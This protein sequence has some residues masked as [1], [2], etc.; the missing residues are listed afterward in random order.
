LTGD[1]GIRAF[2]EEWH[3]PVYWNRFASTSMPDDAHGVHAYSHVNTFASAAAA[4]EVSGDP[5]Y[6]TILRN[7]YDYMQHAQCYATGGYGPNERFTKVDG[8]LGESLTT[9]SDTCETGCGSWAVFKL[10]RYLQR[11]T[12]E[13]RYGDWAE[14]M[15]YNGAGAALPVTVD[16]KNFYYADYRAGGGMKVY[17]YER[18]TCCS[19][20]YIQDIVDLHNLGYY[21]D[22]RGIYVNLYL[23]SE[24]TWNGP[25]GRV[26][27][28]QETRY[29]DADTSTLTIK[30]AQPARFAVRFRIP[31]WTRNATLSINGTAASIPAVPGTWAVVER[32]WHDG[33]RVEITIPL[34]ARV[35][36]VD[37]WH[38]DRVALVRGPVVLVLEGGYHDAQFRVPRTNDD[39]AAA[40]T[41]EPWRPLAGMR[42][43]T[44]PPDIEKVSIFRLASSAQSGTPARGVSRLRAFY[45]M[46]E[47]YPY[48]MYFD[49]SQW[50]RALW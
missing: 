19:G 27:F 1:P 20:T 25:S 8:S 39:L 17:N 50:P 40:L 44:P 32:E 45:D 47:G 3:Y 2:A 33:D 41:P 26:V 6:L 9:R 24:L 23:P 30:P 35:V 36:P 49:R 11:F 46:D 18:W 16:G 31:E 5:R 48:F 13:A 7:F 29:P 43:Q 4:Y 12:G 42:S 10:S 15:L 14:R 37:S 22:A 34:T 28:V 21:K 38:P